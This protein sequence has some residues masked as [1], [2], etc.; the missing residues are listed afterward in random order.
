[1]MLSKLRFW[2]CRQTVRA[3]TLIELLVVIAIIAILAAM[4][5]PALAK[6]KCKAQSIKCL[7][8]LRQW[9]IGFRMYADD[10]HDYVPDEGNVGNGINDTGTATTTDNYDYAWYN[11]VAKTIGRQ[12]LLDFYIANLPPLPSSSTIFSCPQAPKPNPAKGFT[13][14]PKVAKAYFMYGENARLCVNFGTRAAGA[15]QTKLTDILKI[16]QTIFLA[17]V[18]GNDDAPPTGGPSQIPA[19]SQSNVTAYYSI[20]RHCG[21]RGNFSMCDGS[22]ISAGTNSFWESQGEADDATKEWALERKM[23]WYPSPTTKN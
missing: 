13:D 20:A 10:N 16:S 18:D 8:N 15:S 6:A 12:S 2:R 9:G 21:N 23:Y 3:F 19:A 14:P 7:S 22:S 11:C 17:E 1:M 5:L 4:L